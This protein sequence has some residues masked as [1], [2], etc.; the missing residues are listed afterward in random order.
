ME[1]V[2]REAERRDITLVVLPTAKAVGLLRQESEKI[3]AILHVTC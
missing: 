2:R 1:E 3:N